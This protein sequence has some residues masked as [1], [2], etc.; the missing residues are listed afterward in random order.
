MF[1]PQV[2]NEGRTGGSAPVT[3]DR[4]VSIYPTLE[5]AQNIHGV[6][7]IKLDG[8]HQYRPTGLLST[9]EL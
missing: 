7:S 8:L 3:A 2:R 5:A 6:Q 1:I 4:S 9:F